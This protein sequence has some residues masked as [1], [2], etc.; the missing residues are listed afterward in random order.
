M[1]AQETGEYVHGEFHGTSSTGG[2][3]TLYGVDGTAR[4]LG[5]DERLVITDAQAVFSASGDGYIY[6]DADDD[7]TLDVGETV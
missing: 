1:L 6:L 2:E 3:I 7:D 5:S 4:T